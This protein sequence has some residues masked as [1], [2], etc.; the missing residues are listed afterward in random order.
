MTDGFAEGAFA[1]CAAAAGGNGETDL[2]NAAEDLPAV[3][4]DSA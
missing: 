4:P 3:L 1:Q 2:A